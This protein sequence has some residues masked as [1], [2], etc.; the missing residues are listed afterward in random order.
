MPIVDVPRDQWPEF[1]E[2][3]SRQ[4]RAWLA[5]VEQPGRAIASGP[6]WPLVGV[7]AE[8]DGSR[9]SLIEISFDPESHAEMVRVENPSA[10]R[11]DRTTEGADRA[12][13]IVGEHGAWTRISFRTTS[14]PE[15]LDGLAPAE[16]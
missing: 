9:V 11:V 10:V 3:F 8:R 2:T 1:L 4:H 16:L 7:T 5:V 6:G 12:L 13:E 14:M 15:M